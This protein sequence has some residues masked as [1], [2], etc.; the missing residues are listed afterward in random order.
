M[1]RP[2]D[3][4]RARARDTRLTPG[5]RVTFPHYGSSIQGIVTRD[6]GNGIVW[7]RGDAGR[8]RWLHRDSITTTEPANPAA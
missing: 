4:T 5:T 2:D 1:T 3:Q 7:V 6:S 8:E